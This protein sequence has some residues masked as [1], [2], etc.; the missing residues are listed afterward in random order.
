MRNGILMGA[1]IV[2][3]VALVAVQP[4]CSLTQTQSEHAHLYDRDVYHDVGMIPDDVDLLLM[5]DRP[6]RLSRWIVTY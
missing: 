1:L 5:L 2:V 6:T 4:G 3:L